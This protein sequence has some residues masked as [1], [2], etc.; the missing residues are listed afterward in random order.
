VKHQTQH[1]IACKNKHNDASHQRKSKK[2]KVTLT[3]L[4]CA[5]LLRHDASEVIKIKTK[6]NRLFLHIR[7]HFDFS[8]LKSRI[9]S[10]KED[11]K[12][13]CTNSHNLHT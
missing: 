12:R 11:S 4:P 3:H 6:K 2:N 1:H 5:E 9:P 13:G 7:R 8:Y 10:R